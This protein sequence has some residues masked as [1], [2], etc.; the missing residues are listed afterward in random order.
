VWDW[1]DEAFGRRCR[2]RVLLNIKP[3]TTTT[4]EQYLVAIVALNVLKQ[5]TTFK[6]YFNVAPARDLLIITPSLYSILHPPPPRLTLPPTPTTPIRPTRS[7]SHSC[8]PCPQG[9]RPRRR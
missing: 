4:I 2:R 6:A 1:G 5:S 3:T 9:M 7:Q 8:C